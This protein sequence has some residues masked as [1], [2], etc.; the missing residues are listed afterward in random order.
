M[1]WFSAIWLFSPHSHPSKCSFIHSF[2]GY[3]KARKTD[4]MNIVRI[5]F[6]TISRWTAAEESR[7]L[8]KQIGKH[9]QSHEL[10]VLAN[11]VLHV[12]SRM[13]KRPGVFGKQLL[14]LLPMN[15]P[16][17]K[18]HRWRGF[19]WARIS[20]LSFFVERHASGNDAH[21]PRDRDKKNRRTSKGS[22]TDTNLLR[23]CFRVPQSSKQ[24]W[25]KNQ[26]LS[27]PIAESGT[28]P[29][30]GS[31]I[32]PI[33]PAHWGT[34]SSSSLPSEIRLAPLN[35]IKLYTQNKKMSWT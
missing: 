23:D 25:M 33:R 1:F 14:E 28:D 26:K 34:R 20:S 16:V 8:H 19:R 21:C 18:S 32:L 24:H 6:R 17:L 9:R 29:M 30:N 5:T 4:P 7:N 12:D 31:T 27:I 11:D 35:K 3:H 13:A 22:H 10:D 15:Q 2:T